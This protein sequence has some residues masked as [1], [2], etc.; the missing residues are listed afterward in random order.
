MSVSVGCILG[1]SLLLPLCAGAADESGPA[2][3][4]KNLDGILNGTLVSGQGLGQIRIGEPAFPLIT[5]LLGTTNVVT[6]HRDSEVYTYTRDYTKQG[7][8]ITVA[9]P[10]AAGRIRAVSV[11]QTFRGQTEKGVRMGDPVAKVLQLHGKP[12]FH[13][14]RSF[15]SNSLLIYADGTTFGFDSNDQLKGV[16]VE[17]PATQRVLRLLRGSRGNP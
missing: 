6:R 14:E 10:G 7:L 8:Q 17:D 2:P 1:F 11:D 9:P 13:Q 5:D 3:K 4:L 16:E 12:A 15:N